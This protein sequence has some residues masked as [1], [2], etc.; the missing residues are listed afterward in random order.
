V[1]WVKKITIAITLAD[2]DGLYQL[3]HMFYRLLD[4]PNL[5]EF[6][7]DAH[8]TNDFRLQGRDGVCYMLCSI[9]RVC[10]ELKNKLGVGLTLRLRYKHTL[11]REWLED[12]CSREGMED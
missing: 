10:K 9:A 12:Y 6:I 1:P 11:S 4:C 7:I 3:N 5:C 8:R 2:M